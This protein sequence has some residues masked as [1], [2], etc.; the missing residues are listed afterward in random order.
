[1]V[2]GGDI[3][4]GEALADVPG[5]VHGGR[6]LAIVFTCSVCETRSAKKFSA[7]SYERGV[8]VVTC[9][10]CKNNHLIAD[11]LGFFEDDRWDVEKLAAARGESVRRFDDD[12]L[13][14]DLSS[15]ELHAL[16]RG[17][18]PSKGA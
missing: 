2:T 17:A 18:P 5:T 7:D 10:G 9:P 8:V 1:M 15:D 6:R 12:N 3:G 4:G 13:L 16:A 14:G 11:N